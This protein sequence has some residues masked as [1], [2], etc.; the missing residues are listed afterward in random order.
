MNMQR[1]LATF[2]LV[3][4][5]LTLAIAARIIDPEP[6]ARLRFS[7][8]DAY[9]RLM[10]SA[11]NLARGV[12]IVQIDTESLNRIGQWP[13]PRTR[14]AEMIDRLRQ[15]GA[16]VVAL[17]LILAEPDR[18]SPKEFARLFDG[19]PEFARLVAEAARLPSNDE[20][21]A[22]AIGAAP[23]VLGFVAETAAS[24]TLGPPKARLAF[25][26]DD[27]QLFVPSFVGATSS[28]DMLTQRAAG[29]GSVNWLPSSDQIVR[30]VPLIVSVAGK[31]YPSLPLEAARVGMGESTV[32]VRSSGGSGVRAFGQQTGVETVRVGTTALP[33]DA[34]GEMWLRFSQHDAS[35]DISAFRILEGTFERA[36][37]QGRYILIGASAP[38]LLDLR[39]TPLQSAVPGVVVHAQALEQILSG[40]HLSRPVFATGA[41]LV[42]LV[43]FG[44][45]VAY[46]IQR[47]GPI[48]AALTAV[49]AIVSVSATSWV[50][51]RQHG[52]L[53]DPVYPSLVLVALYLAT[54]LGTYIKSEMDR[55]YVRSAFSHYL[56]PPL[57]EELARNHT[58]LK[59]GGEMRDV[60]V[61]FADVRGFSHIAEGLDA[62]A[63][64]HFVNEIFTPLS[65][66]I[67]ARQG[68]ID[69][70]IG[71][72]VMA[73][74]NAPLADH[75]H[76]RH[77]CQAAL[78]MLEAVEELNRMRAAK[79]AAWGVTAAPIRIGIGVNTGECCV[80]NVGS[81]QR[82]DYS[83]LGDPVNI[84]SRLQD[85][86]K[87]YE[88][89]IIAGEHTVAA[90]PEFAFLEIDAITLRG[91]GRPARVFAL[92]GDATVARSEKFRAL[93][94]S[95]NALIKAIRSRDEVAARA[96]LEDCRTLDWPDFD[97]LLETYRDRTK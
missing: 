91:M 15:A 64:I 78:D 8:F 24:G 11:V 7:I 65:K 79:A 90:A 3:A 63:L 95:M 23:V 32:F 67:L 47:S 55:T 10:P 59:L 62:E 57:V 43:V 60:T 56:A 80:G 35:A 31:I 5:L 87:V 4:T 74:W 77:A 71:D 12:K 36:D 44:A 88:L 22:A 68:T 34:N 39:A 41:E 86:T 75:S 97:R 18:L 69:K 9:Q 16:R 13:W 49:A 1:Q 66:V 54:S 46:L 48:L 37:V 94:A 19:R 6:V 20:Q 26:G 25:A 27:P 21:L 38:G 40:A 50:A 70:F 76:A 84:A 2:S 85:E 28:L 51:Y 93:Q 42:F 82:F 53:L 61:M 30:R 33:T 73:F 29:I 92:L 17:D 72:A 14:L 58:R 96:R 81:P 52:L 83:I 89:P 45:L